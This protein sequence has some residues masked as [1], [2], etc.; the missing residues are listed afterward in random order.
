MVLTNHM[1]LLLVSYIYVKEAI[2][3]S[4]VI[5]IIVRFLLRVLVPRSDEGAKNGLALVT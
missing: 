1:N 3:F 5:P 4:K 2:Y